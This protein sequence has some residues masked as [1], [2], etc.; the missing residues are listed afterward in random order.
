MKKLVY[1]LIVCS[2]L[3]GCGKKVQPQQEISREVLR[4]HIRAVSDREED[5]ELK[6]KVKTQVVSYLQWLLADCTS[7]ENCMKKIENNLEQI[8]KVTEAAC[9]RAGFPLETKVYLTRES[10]PLKQ[11]GDMILPSGVYDALRVDLG[12]AKG[13]NWWC[14]MYPSLCMVDGI[15]EEVPKDSKKE[16][17][18]NLSK[19][20]YDSLFW[21][22]E[23]QKEERFGRKLSDETKYHVKWKVIER[24]E[25]YFGKK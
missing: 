16:L 2:F 9:M 12:K 25:K 10:F 18:Q 5:Q 11:Y 7:K 21:T 1:I 20:A 3:T 4:F 24:F 6:L 23:T 15:V 14:M 13:K 19:E 8:E 17:E 22:G